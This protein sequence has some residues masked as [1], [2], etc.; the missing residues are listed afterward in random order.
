MLED[1][2]LHLGISPSKWRVNVFSSCFWNLGRTV[3]SGK[4]NWY[5]PQTQGVARLPCCQCVP[6]LWEKLSPCPWQHLT[7]EAERAS[8]SWGF[9]LKSGVITGAW[10]W[11]E[12]SMSLLTRISAIICIIKIKAL[13]NCLKRIT[14]S[15]AIFSHGNTQWLQIQCICSWLTASVSKWNLLKDGQLFFFFG[16]KKTSGTFRTRGLRARRRPWES[17]GL[18]PC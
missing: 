8:T 2:L 6:T 18:D 7:R 4:S 5:S 16:R 12:L 13:T 11:K 10:N 14:L 3:T 1:E 9:S 15:G 17:A